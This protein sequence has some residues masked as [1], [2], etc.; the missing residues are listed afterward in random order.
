MLSSEVVRYVG[1]DEMVLASV[2]E[3]ARVGNRAQ[4]VAIGI[5]LARAV[6][7]CSRAFPELERL[8]AKA[9]AASGISELATAVAAGLNSIPGFAGDEQVQTD[10]ASLTS[11]SPAAGGGGSR[12]GVGGGSNSSVGAA[13]LTLSLR[14]SATSARRGGRPIM[15][16]RGAPTDDNTEEGGNGLRETVTGTAPAPQVP[17]RGGEPVP[18]FSSKGVTSTY[19]AT[20]SPTR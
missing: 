17:P 16:T 2:I 1:S 15:S 12:A 11:A 14:G 7:V 10:E 18:A 6:S 8:V 9:V 19:G 13:L 4:R 5:G 3:L 20:V